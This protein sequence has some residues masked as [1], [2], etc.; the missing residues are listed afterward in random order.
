MAKNFVQQTVRGNQVIAANPDDINHTLLINRSISTIKDKIN[1]TYERVRGNTSVQRKFGVDTDCATGCK[2]K[3]DASVRIEWSLPQG[4][5]EAD[6]LKF[7]ATVAVPATENALARLRGGETVGF[8]VNPSTS[9]G[10]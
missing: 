2:R 7:I 10:A 9:A 8:A 6:R 4:L 1:G 5:S 3:L